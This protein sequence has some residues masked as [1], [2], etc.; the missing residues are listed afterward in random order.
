M[1]KT[2]LVEPAGQKGPQRKATEAKQ[3]EDKEV[4]SLCLIIITNSYGAVSMP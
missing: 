1:V 2:T 4:I 3:S